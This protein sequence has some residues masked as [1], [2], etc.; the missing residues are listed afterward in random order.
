MIVFIHMWIIVLGF[1]AYPYHL[2]NLMIRC[3][4]LIVVRFA[5][6][7]YFSY[8]RYLLWCDSFD[9]IVLRYF[10]NVFFHSIRRGFLVVLITGLWLYYIIFTFMYIFELLSCSLTRHLPGSHQLQS[11]SY[12]TTFISLIVVV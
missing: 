1:V 3:S 4:L 2:A 6:A 9:F 11:S 5:I 12:I 8:T 10:F 7:I